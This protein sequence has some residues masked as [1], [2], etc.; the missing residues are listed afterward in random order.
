MT[1]SRSLAADAGNVGE[2]K[3]NS[4]SP[5]NVL[6]VKMEN[7]DVV[8]LSIPFVCKNDNGLHDEDQQ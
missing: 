5:V 1:D 7:F 8:S 2:T 6:F 3:M 4:V